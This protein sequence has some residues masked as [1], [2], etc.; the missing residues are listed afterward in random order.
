[1][2]KKL[3]NLI[4]NVEAYLKQCDACLASGGKID[5]KEHERLLAYLNRWLLYFQ[6]ERLIH[7]IVTVLFGLVTI[8]IFGLFVMIERWYI[9]PLLLLLTVLL[10][11]YIFH[12]FNLENGV[13]R[14]YTLVDEME[15]RKE[16]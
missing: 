5:P 2:A 10:V 11:P 14:L 12:Y 16:K 9:L 4:Q 13:Q 3:K 6:H 7:L 15:K 1:M 8:I